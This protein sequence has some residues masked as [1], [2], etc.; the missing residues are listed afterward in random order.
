MD[1]RT[2][3]TLLVSMFALALSS[4]VNFLAP[5]PQNPG[6]KAFAAEYKVEHLKDG[7]WV[8]VKPALLI[9]SDG[10]GHI[11]FGNEKNIGQVLDLNRQITWHIDPPRKVRTHA[12]LVNPHFPNKFVVPVLVSEES[13]RTFYDY[14][15]DGEFNRRPARHY[16]GG[17]LEGLGTTEAWYSPELNCCVMLEVH[18]DFNGHYRNTLMS[19]KDAKP[20][21]ALFDVSPYVEIPC[22][23]FYGKGSAPRR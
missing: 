3:L 20:N 12:E 17:S 8:E 9:F 18:S 23:Q 13:L 6:K 14:K 22:S 11:A 2:K 5:E 19:Y 1:R 10:Q 7:H 16:K 21:A 15:G 4:C